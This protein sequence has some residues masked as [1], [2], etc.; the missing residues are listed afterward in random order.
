MDLHET[1][2]LVPGLSR[3]LFDAK[4][5]VPP[6]QPDAVSHGDLIEAARSSGCRLVAV[7]APAG[8]GKST[9]LAEWAA[10]ED[11]HVAWVSLDRFDD[12][13]AACSPR[14]P[15]HIAGP[16]WPAVT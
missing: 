8:Y 3:L 1:G 14:W 15:P 9:F 4:F 16:A 11:R 12:D 6:P 5:S 2:P 10:T 13:P 7:T